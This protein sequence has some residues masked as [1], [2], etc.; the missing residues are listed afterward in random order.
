M[1][2]VF[3]E[4]GGPFE[5]VTI[6]LWDMGRAVR[7]GLAAEGP[8]VWLR[9][10]VSAY[11]RR[12]YAREK[13]TTVPEGA[14]EE[15]ASHAIVKRACLR[16]ALMGGATGTVTTATSLAT[17]QSNGVLGVVALPVAAVAVSAE[18][19]AR[20]AVHLE[21]ICEL[22]ELFGLRFNPDDPADIWAL[23]ALS[24][25]PADDA[26]SNPPRAGDELVHLARVQA[27]E[28]ARR[29]GRFIIGE[30]LLR[31]ALPV[32]SIASS[33]V[34][35]YVVTRRLGD[36]ARRYARYRRAFD[37]VLAG[38]KGLDAHL[39]LIIEG[40]W[41]IFTAD[42]RLE[43]EESALLASLVRR[44][45]PVTYARISDDLA[46][47]IGWVKRLPRI[48]EP[49]RD[50]FL[51]VLEVAAAVDK[52]ATLRERALI[53]HAATALGRREDFTGLSRMMRDF[54]EHG[55]LSDVS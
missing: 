12:Y 27:E 18:A 23:L 51:R 2:S 50:P 36:N 48:P 30:S 43:P 34:L 3:S 21:M 11:L 28:V 26:R 46:D 29:M 19:V 20:G 32:V 17:A 5:A 42:G 6:P 41:F 10:L 52:K 47:D 40:A 54:R 55:V 53:Q 14:T 38:E 31:N 9:R 4:R 8:E 35:S 22:A 39:D 13:R 1:A 7:E 16:S 15:A 44:A 49:L 25:N 45:S 37:D 24:F 33:S